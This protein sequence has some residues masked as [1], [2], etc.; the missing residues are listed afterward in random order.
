MKTGR[1]SAVRVLPSKA[2]AD[3]KAAEL[4][5]GHYVVTRPGTSKKCAE[6]CSCC[7]FCNFY[8]NIVKNQEPSEG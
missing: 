1:K 3:M 6:Y 4:G 8:N 5:A 7:D 2:E